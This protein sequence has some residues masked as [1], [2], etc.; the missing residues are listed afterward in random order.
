MLTSIYPDQKHLN[1]Y[2]TD[3]KPQINSGENRDERARQENSLARWEYKVIHININ[4]TITSQKEV[5]PEAASKKLQGSLSPKFIEQEFP[6]LYKQKP[7]T[8]HPAEQLQNFMN[9][10]GTE[11]WE[12]VETADV[13]EMLMFF[14]K[15]EII[16]EH[17]TNID[18]QQKKDIQDSGS[19]IITPP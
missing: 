15:R 19:K 4:K 17:K 5:S 13:G 18:E 11:G 8:K 10:L 1:N 7:S 3:Q 14:F 6:Q 2:M 12:L 16:E 9:S